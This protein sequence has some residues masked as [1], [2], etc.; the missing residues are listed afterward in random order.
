MKQCS[1]EKYNTCINF[2]YGKQDGKCSA[3]TAPKMEIETITLDGTFE[4][5]IS[6][7][8]LDGSKK[9][10]LDMTSIK[11]SQER[12]IMFS[13]DGTS[14]LFWI[15]LDPSKRKDNTNWVR[16]LNFGN[17]EW[18]NLKDD[19]GIAIN[20]DLSRDGLIFY[21]DSNGNRTTADNFGTQ[22]LDNKWHHIAWILSPGND[23]TSP[24]W[25]IYH[26]GSLLKTIQK[27]YP[28]NKFRNVKMIGGSAFQKDIFWGPKIGE[29]RMYNT[30]LD[31]ITMKNIYRY[32]ISQ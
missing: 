27:A 7:T 28:L 5:K 22:I 10:Y 3:A 2:T 21:H 12:D 14:I 24:F 20:N 18:E 15:K 30:I 8:S 1:Q 11:R 23:T 25:N 17:R 6:F 26:N 13:P 29:F 16:L 19:V 4:R 9:E 32:G 31:E